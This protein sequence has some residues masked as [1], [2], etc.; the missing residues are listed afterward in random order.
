MNLAIEPK[1]PWS[2]RGLR[3]STSSTTF[4]ATAIRARAGLLNIVLGGTIALTALR[5]EWNAALVVT[6]VLLLDMVAAALFGLTPLSPTGVA[7]TLLTRSL[8]AV[9]TP[10][11]PKRF[12]WTL[13][14]LLSLTCLA[15]ALAAPG[16]GPLLGTLALF[17]VLT[18][19]DAALGF[20]VGCWIYSKLFGCSACR[21][22]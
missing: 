20:C 13:G 21:A 19:L 2:A 11:M 22:G 6:P 17:F 9:P 12:A 1:S 7:A 3:A 10:H 18:W 4:D 15:L 5:P 8:P 16:Q 14:V